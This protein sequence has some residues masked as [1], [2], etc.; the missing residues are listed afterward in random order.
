V[1]VLLTWK[2]LLNGF[3]LYIL[4]TS[5]NDHT[6]LIISLV[7]DFNYPWIIP[8]DIPYVF[9][10]NRCIASHYWHIKW[11]ESNFYIVVSK[12]I[13]YKNVCELEKLYRSR[14]WKI[15]CILNYKMQCLRF[16]LNEKP[17]GFFIRTTCVVFFRCTGRWYTFPIFEWR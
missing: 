12:R 7:N 2:Y 4:H 3:P 16:E 14:W 13:P 9:S 17:S 8:A 6:V 1:L 10:Y 15:I 11:S 5:M